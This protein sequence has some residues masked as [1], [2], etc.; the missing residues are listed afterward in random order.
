MTA[1]TV[2]RVDRLRMLAAEQLQR[3]SWSRDQLLTYQ[4]ERLRELLAHAVSASAR[5]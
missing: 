2:S 5:P 3:E 4:H 1:T